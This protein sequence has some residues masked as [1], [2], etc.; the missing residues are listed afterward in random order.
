MSE[1]TAAGPEA[2]ARHYRDDLMV[3]LQIQDRDVKI[4]KYKKELEQKPAEVEA[5]KDTLLHGR[6]RLD[7]QREGIKKLESDRKSLELDLESQ[8]EK[9]HKLEVQ[10][11]QVKTNEEYRAMLK[12]IDELKKENTILEDKILDVM[13]KIE[14]EK[15][16][17]AQEEQLLKGEEQ[18]AVQQEQ[19]IRQEIAGIQK[20]LEEITREKEGMLPRVRPELLE[21]YKTIFE[22]KDDSAIVTID[23]GACGGCHMA[24]TPQV[25]NEVKRTSEPV[26]CEN[27]AR[28]LCLPK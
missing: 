19:V 2:G 9:M 8:I 28:I 15:K 12:E 20:H 16:R 23:H 21:R 27:C 7:V 24:I 13:E 25:L 10:S 14:E 3:L 6:K 22:N 11:S 5:L 17:V 1:E 26:I 4:R 18:K